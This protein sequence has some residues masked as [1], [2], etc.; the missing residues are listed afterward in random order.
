MMINQSH[1][2]PELKVEEPQPLLLPKQLRSKMIQIQEQQS[3]PPSRPERFP[4]HPQSL[5]M[6]PVAAKSLIIS[7]Q[8]Y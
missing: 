7:L 2:Q 5:F 1:P 4:E 8:N 6:H 3:L